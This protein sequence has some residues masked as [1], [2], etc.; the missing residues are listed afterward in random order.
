V[1][2]LELLDD[3]QLEDLKLR[4]V[5]LMKMQGYTNVEIA[6]KLGCALRSVERK[7]RLIRTQWEREDVP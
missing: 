5:A 3:P 6:A 4:L 2:L 7:L 1:H